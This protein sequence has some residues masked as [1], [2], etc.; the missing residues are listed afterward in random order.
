MTKK[1]WGK[2]IFGRW[3]KSK[4]EEQ[5]FGLSKDEIVACPQC[6]AVYYYKS[7]HH[8]LLNYKGVSTDKGFVFKLCPADQM[9]KDGFFEGEV[10]VENFPKQEGEEIL[11]LIKNIGEKAYGRDVLDRIFNT[12]ILDSKIVVTTSENQLA[13]QIGKSI[14]KAKKGSKLDESFSEEDVIRMRVYWQ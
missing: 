3:P 2:P 6:D 4:K 1:I 9:K 12:E 7:W 13:K 14:N 5:E 8:N 10:V 11:N